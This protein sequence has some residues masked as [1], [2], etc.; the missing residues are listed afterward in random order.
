MLRFI[1]SNYLV[2]YAVFLVEY[3]IVLLGL[4]K[5]QT[6]ESRAAVDRAAMERLTTAEAY[7]APLQEECMAF[8][9]GPE[10]AAI[11]KL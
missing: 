8:A 3:V 5:V 6:L 2:E 10:G 11:L 7:L 4:P 9:R 1:I